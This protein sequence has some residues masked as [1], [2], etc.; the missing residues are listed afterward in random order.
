MPLRLWNGYF[1]YQLSR[2]NLAQRGAKGTHVLAPIGLW[3]SIVEGKY[4][5]RI[6][7]NANRGIEHGNLAVHLD[8]GDSMKSS[9]LKIRWF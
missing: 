5:E 3:F 8:C 6:G 2:R 9:Y 4:V 7:R 1:F